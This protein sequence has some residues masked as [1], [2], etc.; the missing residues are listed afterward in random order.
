M[1]T[2][3]AQHPLTPSALEAARMLANGFL[4]ITRPQINAQAQTA[5]QCAV[6]LEDLVATME[7]LRCARRHAPLQWRTWHDAW[8]RTVQ[9][10][11]F[12]DLSRP[13]PESV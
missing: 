3:Y 6:A 7:A 2:S 12:A 5:I 10:Y 13:R 1:N 8:L 11:I 4:P 9:H